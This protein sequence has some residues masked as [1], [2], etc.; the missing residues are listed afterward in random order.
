MEIE[1]N[2]KQITMLPNALAHM[3]C[4]EIPMSA[5]FQLDAEKI[6]IVETENDVIEVL[7]NVYHC[8]LENLVPKVQLALPEIT[9]N[10][11]HAIHLC[12]EMDMLIVQNV[13]KF[14]LNIV[15]YAFVFF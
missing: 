15:I 13:R 1:Q 14:Y 12:K 10:L 4:K 9:G 8:A 11:A 3:D 2:V 6:Q 7:K 5:V